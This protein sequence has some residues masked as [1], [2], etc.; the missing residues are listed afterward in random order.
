MKDKGEFYFGLFIL[1]IIIGFLALSISYSPTARL[2]PM[3]IAIAGVVFIGLQLLSSLPGFSEKLSFL[4][5]KKDFF[6]T[7]VIKGK[8]IRSED[9]LTDDKAP[10]V[11]AVPA[12]ESFLWVILFGSSIFLFGF[13]LAV[14][15]LVCI[16]LKYRARA[17]WVFSV[18][19]ALGIEFV[20]YFGFVVLLKVFLYKGYLF[21]LIMGR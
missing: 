4:S 14:P 18:V 5:Q 13:L 6:S 10:K 15:I 2:V 21:I 8:K 9:E 3:I 17:G 20:M 7:A 16:Y 19:S 1:L 12:R 11:D